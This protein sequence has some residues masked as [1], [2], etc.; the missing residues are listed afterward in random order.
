MGT[1]LHLRSCESKRGSRG[2]GIQHSPQ[3]GSLASALIR[4][5]LCARTA[6]SIGFCAVELTAPQPS[7]PRVAPTVAVL[8]T[9]ARPNLVRP[10]TWTWSLTRCRT[11]L[12]V[13]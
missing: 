9:P 7:V 13:S 11:L 8:R 1:R 10:A 5:L 4:H 6:G 2:A 3:Y 12:R